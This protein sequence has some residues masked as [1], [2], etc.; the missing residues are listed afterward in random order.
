[1]QDMKNIVFKLIIALI[2][3][4]LFYACSSDEGVARC[5]DRTVGNQYQDSICFNDCRFP[6]CGCDNQTYCNE[7]LAGKK[8]VAVNYHHPCGQDRRR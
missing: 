3:G 7:C 1:M 6:V 2:A 5:T 4:V 8:G